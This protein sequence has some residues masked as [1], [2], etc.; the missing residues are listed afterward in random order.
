MKRKLSKKLTTMLTVLIL[1][2]LIIPAGVLFADTMDGDTQPPTTETTAIDE[3]ED[4][5]E[6]EE[7]EEPEDSQDPEESEEA[8]D[9]EESEDP[10]ETGL[11]DEASEQA[12]IVAERIATAE[13]LGIAP[14]YLN[15]IDRLAAM[16]GNTLTREELLAKYQDGSVQDIM[17]EIKRLRTEQKAGQPTEETEGTET[18]ARTSHGHAYGKN[19]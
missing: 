7:T 1:M 15:I 16:P 9:I 10:D 12:K 6:P 8:E 17:K 18:A 2:L 13:S 19:K 14:G 4:S 5:Q 3:P 11:P